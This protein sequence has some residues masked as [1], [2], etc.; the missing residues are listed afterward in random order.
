M[1]TTFT[2]IICSLFMSV[3]AFA[4]DLIIYTNGMELKAKVTEITDTEVKYKSLDNLNGPVYTVLKTYIFMIKYE[5][6]TKDVFNVQPVVPVTPTASVVPVSPNA[7]KEDESHPEIRHYGGPRLGLTFVGPGVLAD[8]LAAQGKRQL[9]SQFGWQFETRMFTTAD[10]LSGLLEFVPLISMVDMGKFTPSVTGIIGIRTKEG[11][12]FGVG[13]SFSI[14]T[15]YFGNTQGSFGVV[16]A[17]GVSGK[18]GNACF[19]VNIAIEPSI[20]KVG[21]VWDPITQKSFN[22]EYK[23]GVK[24]S[25]LVGFNSRTK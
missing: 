5:N 13:P 8:D 3:A 7:A 9:F 21:T 25:L 17:A 24:I 23:T 11:N 1:K 19:P 15:N 2:A 22:K 20:T 18:S 6:G 16:I 10:G 4:Q 12:E 14:Y